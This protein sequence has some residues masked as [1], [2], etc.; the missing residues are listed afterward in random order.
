VNPDAVAHYGPERN[1]N[2]PRQGSA[3]PVPARTRQVRYSH[4][5]VG[6]VHL[7]RARREAKKRARS[8]WRNKV[9]L[10]GRTFIDYSF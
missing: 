8:T 7:K 9:E 6:I 3:R 2:L 4:F 5:S 1:L 10:P